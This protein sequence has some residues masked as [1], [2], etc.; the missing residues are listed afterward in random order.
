MKKGKGRRT[1]EERNRELL[2]AA[3][4][5]M[6]LEPITADELQAAEMTD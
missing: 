4:E 3:F 5:K 1:K 6:Q 2:L